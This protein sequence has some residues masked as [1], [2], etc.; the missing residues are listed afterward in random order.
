MPQVGAAR[1]FV[2]EGG[3]NLM[4]LFEDKSRIRIGRFRSSISAIETSV[5]R[6]T[7]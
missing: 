3:K 6:N 5:V 1:R 4:N 7:F 2:R